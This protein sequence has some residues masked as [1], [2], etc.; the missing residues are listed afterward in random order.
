MLAF[1]KFFQYV[2]AG[3]NIRV[4]FA[5]WLNTREL[6]VVDVWVSAICEQRMD[7]AF[8]KKFLIGKSGHLCVSSS[9]FALNGLM[10]KPNTL[11][12]PNVA[13]TF[14]LLIIKIG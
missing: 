3:N 9:E 10:N 6:D 5:A 1:C 12:P 11:V 14:R 13:T 7:G 4:D 8:L 2:I